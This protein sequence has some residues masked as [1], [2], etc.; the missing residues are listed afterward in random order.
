MLYND[1]KLHLLKRDSAEQYKKKELASF[2]ANVSIK[3]QNP[4]K[5]NEVRVAS[6]EYDRD[7]YRSFFNLLWKSLFAG[8]RQTVGIE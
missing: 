3:D 2:L 4:G 8:I 7:I 6:V 5:N 1:L